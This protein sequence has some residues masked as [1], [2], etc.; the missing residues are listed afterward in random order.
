MMASRILIV[1]EKDLRQYY[2][3]AP[4]LSWGFLFPLAIIVLLSFSAKAYGE[5]VVVPGMFSV[6]L[7]FSSTSMAQVAVSFEKMN[8]SLQRLVYSPLSVDELLAAKALGGVLYGVLGSLL[9]V[10]AV[11]LLTGHVILLHTLFFSAAVIIVALNYSLLSTAISLRFEPVK[12]VAVLNLARFLMVFLGGM[13]IPRILMPGLLQPAAYLFPSLYA[14]EALRY[15]L[16]NTWDLVDPYTSLIV[17]FI[18]T[19]ALFMVSRR[20]LEEVMT[21]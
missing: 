10:T 12:G 5:D 4:V 1:F 16:Y 14:T 17:L 11:R 21:P 20:L 13:V 15:S 6:A 9:A 3:K 8:G 7:L 2:S 18:T 19:A